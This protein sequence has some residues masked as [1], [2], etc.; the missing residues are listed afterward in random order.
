M[1]EHV[2]PLVEFSTVAVVADQ[3]TECRIGQHQID[4]SPIDTDRSLDLNGIQA[5]R[6]QDR[7]GVVLET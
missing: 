4:F 1:N 7:Q 5:V 3:F 2:A 6:H